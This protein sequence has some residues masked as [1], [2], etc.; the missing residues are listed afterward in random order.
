MSETPY[1]NSIHQHDYFE[2]HYITGG[3]GIY[4]F[5]NE[6]KMIQKGDFVY[7]PSNEAH[8]LS[9]LQKG[10]ILQQIYILIDITDKPLLYYLNDTK[11][12]GQKFIPG[13][14]CSCLIEKMI[15]WFS[16][17][18]LELLTLKYEFKSQ[19]LKLIL[20]NDLK[21]RSKEDVMIERCIQMM[22][23][24]I[25]STLKLVDLSSLINTSESY[26]IKL[27]NNSVKSTPHKYFLKL[28]IKQSLLIINQNDKSIEQIAEI[29]GFTDRYHYGRVFKKV[30]GTTIKTYRKN[31]VMI[32]NDLEN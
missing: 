31:T 25:H 8:F 27:F 19:I 6:K 18:E 30:M 11:Y 15:N 28:K 13:S 29:F 26:L 7:F 23:D 4:L 9:P 21:A 12:S 24:N 16:Y 2:F 10:E 20:E 14:Q 22:L 17:R 3:E 32:Y 5:N 1:N